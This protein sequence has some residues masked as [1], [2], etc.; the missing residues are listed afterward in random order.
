[1][2]RHVAL[3]LCL[4]V[5]LSLF[6]W[7]ITSSAASPSDLPPRS[8]ATPLTPKV[9]GSKVCFVPVGD[10]PSEQLSRLVDYYR[11]RYNL[12][13]SISKAIPV[14]PSVRDAARGQLMAEEFA[15]SIRRSVPEY[16]DDLNTIL[17]GFTS[18]DMYPTSQDWQFAFGWRQG[19]TRTA[20]VSTARLDLTNQGIPAS[21]DIVSSRLRKIVTKDIGILYYGLPQSGNP[22]SVLYNQIMGIEEL[23]QIGEDF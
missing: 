4:I 16:A 9:S 1:M 11:L 14:D 12:E 23:D 13:I 18:E 21:A 8:A 5:F 15:L 17:I 6:A 20:V 19:T 22:Q 7:H 3:G 2:N 10:F